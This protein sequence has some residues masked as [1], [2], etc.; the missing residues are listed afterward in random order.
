MDATESRS[1]KH[2]IPATRIRIALTVVSRD[3]VP[4]SPR[5]LNNPRLRIS[6]STPKIVP[7]IPA[8]DS[9]LL[10]SK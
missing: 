10:V 9:F 5:P 2:M 3:D 7:L 1:T 8:S 6:N 4:S